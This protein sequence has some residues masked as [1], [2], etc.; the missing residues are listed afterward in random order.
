VDVGCLDGAV[1]ALIVGVTGYMCPPL[2]VATKLR[3][4]ADPA[5][6]LVA[7]DGVQ[8]AEKES[9]NRVSEKKVLSFTS[10]GL[11]IFYM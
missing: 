2:H 3:D 6:P 11:Y 5:S 8:L 4:E 9:R 7:H 1:Y 10:E